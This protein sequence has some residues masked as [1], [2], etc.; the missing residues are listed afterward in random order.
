MQCCKSYLQVVLS[1]LKKYKFNKDFVRKYNEG[2]DLV[3]FVE[4][5]VQHPEKLQ[6]FH[7]E[8]PFFP[9]RMKF[10]KVEKLVATLYD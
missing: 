8:L 4:A 2:S 5:D 1:G 3:Y 6:C 7:N 9:E 10:G